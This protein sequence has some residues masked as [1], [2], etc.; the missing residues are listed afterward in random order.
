MML[1]EEAEVRA[2]AANTQ[3]ARRAEVMAVTPE[4]KGLSVAGSGRNRGRGNSPTPLST[5]TGCA[6][7]HAAEKIPAFAIMSN[8]T[9]LSTL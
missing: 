6:T 2:D 1:A 9:T 4:G 5:R 3:A 7:H 8:K